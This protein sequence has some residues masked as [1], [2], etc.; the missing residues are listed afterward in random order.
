MVGPQEEENV[1]RG[2]RGGRRVSVK[3]RNHARGT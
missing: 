3:A 2:G 1:H